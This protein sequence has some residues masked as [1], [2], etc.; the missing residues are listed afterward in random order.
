MATYQKLL[1]IYHKIEKK[2]KNLYI[3]NYQIYLDEPVEGP[4]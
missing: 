3:I 1:M 4:I 2:G